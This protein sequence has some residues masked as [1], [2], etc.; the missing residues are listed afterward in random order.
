MQATELLLWTLEWT[1]YGESKTVYFF[2]F[3]LSPVDNRV[4][5]RNLGQGLL[6]FH[7]QL[8]SRPVDC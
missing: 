1:I 7:L 3:T 4:V 2:L 5:K 6:R 8:A